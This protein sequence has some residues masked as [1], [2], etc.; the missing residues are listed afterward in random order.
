MNDLWQLIQYCELMLAKTNCAGLAKLQLVIPPVGKK[1]KVVSTADCILL[2]FGFV[3]GSIS[4][5]VIFKTNRCS[6]YIF[7]RVKGIFTA[8]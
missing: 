4:K 1:T 8:I 5:S 2:C 7:S 6:N 3:Q